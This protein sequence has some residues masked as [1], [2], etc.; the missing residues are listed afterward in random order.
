[1]LACPGLPRRGLCC[2]EVFA[3]LCTTVEQQ[4]PF[5]AYPH[6]PHGWLCTAGAHPAALTFALTCN[7]N[8]A[9]DSGIPSRAGLGSSKQSPDPHA[10][11]SI[12]S[13]RSEQVCRPWRVVP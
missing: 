7:C 11:S 2:P 5:S 3:T 8:T 13:M 10:A 4:D 1:V 6:C 12:T 9:G